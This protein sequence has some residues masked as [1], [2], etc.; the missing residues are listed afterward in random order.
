MA[1][2]Q[3]AAGPLAGCLV[4]DRVVLEAPPVE[5]T[6]RAVCGVSALTVA[7][8]SI[9]LGETCDVVHL[10][11]EHEKLR[12]HRRHFVSKF[13]AVHV[14]SIEDATTSLGIY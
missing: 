4:E 10:A 9:E 3:S 1:G 13:Q 6:Q 8:T 14:K 11:V 12:H 5:R 2:G 7:M